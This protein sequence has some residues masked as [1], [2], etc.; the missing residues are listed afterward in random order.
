MDPADKKLL[1]RYRKGDSDALEQLVVKYRRCLFAYILGKTSSVHE[2]EEVFQEVWLR[3][4]RKLP[5]FRERNL[6]GWLVRIAHNLVIDRARRNRH[7]I[8]LDA[9][10]QEGRSLREALPAGGPDPSQQTAGKEM[11]QAIQLAVKRLPE[12]Q[13]EVFRMRT[14]AGLAFKEI[15]AVQRVSINTALARMQYAL[16]K[17]RPVVRRIYDESNTRRPVS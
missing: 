13:R 9:G 10:E 16:A 11:V 4:I 2:A 17:L 5:L 15:A 1:A 8:S 3:A 14:Q 12:E 7:E 6:R